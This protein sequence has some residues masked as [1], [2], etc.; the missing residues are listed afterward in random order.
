MEESMIR[1]LGAFLDTLYL[2]VYQT[3]T[4]FQVVKKKLPNELKLELQQ[5]KEQAQE[6][7]E[8]IPTR[9][10]SDGKPLLMMLKG[11]EG[12]NWILRNESINFCCTWN[13]A[14]KSIGSRV[15]WDIAVSRSQKNT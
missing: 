9:F 5:I 8:N 4:S 2:N 12:F 6:E 10:S 15:S 1:L 11:S 7:E 14:A 13:K 3:D